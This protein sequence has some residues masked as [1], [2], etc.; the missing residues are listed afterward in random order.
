MCFFYIYIYIDI[1]IYTHTYI[2]ICCCCRNLLVAEATV[3]QVLDPRTLQVLSKFLKRGLF[4]TQPHECASQ[5]A[6]S[7]GVQ[8]ILTKKPVDPTRKGNNWM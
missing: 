1:Y 3:E 5:S 2:C 8:Q 6:V 7:K 4:A